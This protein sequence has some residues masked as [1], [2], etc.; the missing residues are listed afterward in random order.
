[1]SF[2]P[3][4]YPVLAVICL[5][6]LIGTAS[7]AVDEREMSVRIDLSGT[8]PQFEPS[9]R[10]ERGGPPSCMGFSLGDPCITRRAL[11]QCRAVAAQ[12]RGGLVQVIQTCP[13]Q[14]RCGRRGR[15]NSSIPALPWAG[16]WHVPR[17]P[18]IA[19]IETLTV[20]VRKS[21]P[22]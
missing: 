4:C 3:R 2:I 10:A 9:P 21:P 6:L 13:L 20:P 18:R 22:R 11:G 1:M 16:P 19:A 14:F 7:G 17:V 5:G 8:K 12:C 15:G